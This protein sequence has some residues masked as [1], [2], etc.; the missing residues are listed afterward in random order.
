MKSYTAFYN[1]AVIV[2]SDTYVQSEVLP[3]GSYFCYEGA[4]YHTR[5]VNGTPINKS[6]L[7]AWIKLLLLLIN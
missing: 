6:D 7:P 5:F 2:E 3:K 1:N 4:W